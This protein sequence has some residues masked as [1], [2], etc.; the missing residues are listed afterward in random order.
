MQIWINLHNFIGS[1][2]YNKMCD[3]YTQSFT[4]ILKY[5]TKFVLTINLI[6]EQLS[7]KWIVWQILYFLPTKKYYIRNP[8]KCYYILCVRCFLHLLCM[9]VII[10]ILPSQNVLKKCSAYVNTFNRFC[11]N[12]VFSYYF[13]FVLCIYFYIICLYDY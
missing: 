9:Y 12:G 13:F 8:Y 4:I 7:T 2:P 5:L 10:S 1:K 6:F 3:V 11:I